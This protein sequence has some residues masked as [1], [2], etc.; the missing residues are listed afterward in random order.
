MKNKKEKFY[1]TTP[2]Y[3]PSGEPHLGHAYCTI[4]ADVI[5]RYKRLL[6]LDVMFLTGTDEHGQ[7]I[8]N[9]EEYRC[10]LGHIGIKET[11]PVNTRAA[12]SHQDDEDIPYYA[13]PAYFGIKLPK[14]EIAED[15]VHHPLPVGFKSFLPVSLKL[16]HA[17]FQFFPVF[18]FHRSFLILK[19][20]GTIS[21][22]FIL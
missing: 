3:Y 12:Y 18:V 2:I 6:G 17:F 20:I 4:A 9:E 19:I 13:A 16:L 14:T 22:P 11:Q 10:R 1:V 21:Y 15:A 7:K 5:A 8:E